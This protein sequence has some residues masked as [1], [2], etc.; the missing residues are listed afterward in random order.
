[1]KSLTTL[2]LDNVMLMDQSM[3]YILS[4]CPKL[5]E[6]MLWFCYGHVREVLLNSNLK[7]LELGVRWLGTRIHASCGTVEVLD[8]TNVASIVE[9][10]VNLDK[11]TISDLQLQIPSSST[12]FCEMA[13]TRKLNLLKHCPCLKNLIIEI[14]SYYESTSRC[15]THHVKTVQVAGHVMEKQVIQFLE[16]LLGHSVVLKKMMIFAENE[17][18]GPVS[19]MSDKAHEQMHQKPLPL[20]QCS[21]TEVNLSGVFA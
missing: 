9:V 21:S 13:P 3:D 7:T 8:I 16:Y 11:S 6:L 2:C 1:M 4:G 20:L 10:F 5:E 18:Y 17:I 12:G 14:T 19:L 15:L